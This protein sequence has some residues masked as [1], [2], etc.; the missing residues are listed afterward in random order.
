MINDKKL[1]IRYDQKQFEHVESLAKK[2]NSSKGGVVRAA[3]KH[4]ASVMNN[5]P[6]YT[7]NEALNKLAAQKEK[8]QKALEKI[9]NQIAAI[10]NDQE[11]KKSQQEG[12]TPLHLEFVGKDGMQGAGDMTIKVN[13]GGYQKTIKRS[14]HPRSTWWAVKYEGSYWP[15]WVNSQGKMSIT[16]TK[17]PKFQSGRLY[18]ER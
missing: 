3:L 11:V 16:I 10:K 17:N 5:G 9:N 7:A 4:Y 8:T 12:L 1:T 2:Y 15:V 18:L 6:W 14:L 13:D